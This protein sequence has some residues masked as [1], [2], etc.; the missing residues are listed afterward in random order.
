M[1]IKQNPRLRIRKPWNSGNNLTRWR[2]TDL[3]PVAKTWRTKNPSKEFNLRIRIDIDFG[4]RGD[5]ATMRL[6]RSVHASCIRAEQN[7]KLYI[8]TCFR[9]NSLINRLWDNCI[10]ASFWVKSTC[11]VEKVHGRKD[12]WYVKHQNE[13]NIHSIR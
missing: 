9:P 10:W 5:Y 6:V 3:E 4:K 13:P 7:E 11:V 8:N 2:T 12:T 1:M